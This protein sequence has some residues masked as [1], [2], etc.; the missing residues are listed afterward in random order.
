MAK[1]FRLVSDAT[2][3]G[4]PAYVKTTKIPGQLVATRQ[5][6]PLDQDDLLDYVSTVY[7]NIIW[8]YEGLKV[9]LSR[10]ITRL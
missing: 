7:P 9:I 10:H 4:V 8:S 3:L 6:Y 5:S 2:D 1:I